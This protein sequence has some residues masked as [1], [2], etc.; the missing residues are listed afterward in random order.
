MTASYEFG[1]EYI[2]LWENHL[3]TDIVTTETGC[4]HGYE[5]LL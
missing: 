4:S 5:E 2:S 3:I 1:K